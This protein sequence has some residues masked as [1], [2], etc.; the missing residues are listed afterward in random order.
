[1]DRFK[2]FDVLHHECLAQ[3][4]LTLHDS[5]SLKDVFAQLEHKGIK[6]K[7]L[8]C[9]RTTD[10]VMYATFCVERSSLKTAH[11]ILTE[12]LPPET[13]VDIFPDAGMVGIHGPHFDEQPGILDVM[14]NCL[15][16]RG[17][18]ILAISTTISTSF[19]ILPVSE[20]V[21]AIDLLKE[22]FEI[23]QGKI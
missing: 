2:V 12:Q 4:S 7:F 20:V 3:I 18:K 5:T 13:P 17:L 1:M 19:F 11:N 9:N 8:A 21:K 6:I 15:S 10:A 16:S 14:H 23:P 22:A